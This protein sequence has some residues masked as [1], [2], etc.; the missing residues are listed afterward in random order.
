MCK[1]T[2]QALAATAVYVALSLTLAGC[3]PTFDWRQG[4]SADGAVQALFP[5][6]PQL[7]ERQISLAALPGAP[8]QMAMK[9]CAAGGLTFALIS[10]DIGDP[11]LVAAALD[12][13]ARSGAN[14]LAGS[15]QRAASA[16]LQLPGATPHAGNRRL[17]VDGQR[18]DG[19]A[20]QWRSAV[21]THGTR[22]YQASVLG[23]RVGAEV[24]DT[25][26]GSL[27]LQPGHGR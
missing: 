18:P 17:A 10:A 22:V 12:E 16:A 25:F 9:A 14:N 19:Q 6:K 11:R 1:L 8:L 26:F 15:G 3:S 4:T 23:E 7:H 20:A 5:C 13:L 27:V 21:F 2:R 24:A